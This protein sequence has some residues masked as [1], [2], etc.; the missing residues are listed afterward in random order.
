MKWKIPKIWEGGDCWII[1]GG[2]SMPRQFGVPSDVIDKVRSGEL[3]PSSY[4]SYMHKIHDKHVI[5]VNS[6]YKLGDWIDIVT[7]GDIDW[8][9][10][11]RQELLKKKVILVAF[12]Q[13]EEDIKYAFDGIRTVPRNLDVPKGLS[14]KPNTVSWNKNT[15][16]ASI[17]LAY[18]LGVKRIFLLGFDMKLDDS[19]KQHWHGLYSSYNRTEFAPHKL[20][21]GWHL[22]KI[23]NIWEQSKRL[24]FEIINVTDDSAIKHFPKVQLNDVL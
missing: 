17:N 5:G 24:G 3:P 13:I 9:K 8:Y 16:L 19:K 4:S 10:A 20:P 1:G 15:G 18:H 14:T 21:F 23:P 6:A 2:P 22:P 12:N 7:F 11:N